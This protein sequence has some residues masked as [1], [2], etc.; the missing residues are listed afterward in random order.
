LDKGETI[1]I[2]FCRIIN[3]FNVNNEGIYAKLV[4]PT[5]PEVTVAERTSTDAIPFPDFPS[6]ETL[7]DL[8]LTKKFYSV[9]AS[10]E[11]TFG[12]KTV[13]TELNSKSVI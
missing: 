9:L 1:L 11:I 13:S 10:S 2:E 7:V 5:V 4:I 8:T 6:V 3:A 12:F